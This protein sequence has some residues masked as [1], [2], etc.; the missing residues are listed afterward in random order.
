MTYKKE[1]LA[2]LAGVMD[3]DGWITLRK[4]GRTKMGIRTQF[5]LKIGVGQTKRTIVDWIQENFG[6]SIYTEKR[7]YPK[8]DMHRWGA[9]SKTAKEILELIY[10]Y[11][12]MK[13]EQAKLALEFQETILPK[14]HGYKLGLGGLQEIREKMVESMH[15]LNL[16]GKLSYGT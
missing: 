10:P 16:K 12:K 5:V 9:T 2:Y 13:K 6:G 7:P 11:L 3:S 1:D 15:V 4:N 8:R 14:S